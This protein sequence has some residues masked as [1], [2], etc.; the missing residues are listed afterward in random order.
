MVLDNLVPNLRGERLRRN[1]TIRDSEIISGFTEGTHALWTRMRGEEVIVT[2]P[3]SPIIA[4][5]IM[6]TPFERLVASH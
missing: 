3:I 6:G 4:D 1:G 2:T 5:R